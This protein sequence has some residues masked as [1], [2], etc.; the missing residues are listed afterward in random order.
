MKISIAALLIIL[1]ST[2]ACSPSYYKKLSKSK[3]QQTLVNIPDYSN[4]QYWAAHPHKID[5]SDSVPAPFRN[6][7]RDSAVDVFFIHPTTFTDPARIEEFNA[8]LTDDSLNIKTDY[9]SILYQASV[10]NGDCRVFAP[11]YRQAHIGMYRYKD[12]ARAWQAFDT[13]YADIRAAFIHYLEKYKG[14]PIIIASHSQGTQH[15]KRLLKEFFDGQTLGNRLVA[16]YLLG[17]PVDQQEFNDIPVC[18]DSTQTGCFVSWRTFRR[19]FEGPEYIARETPK[20]VV[21]PLTWKADTGYAASSL[22]KGAILYKFNKLIKSPN[23]AQVHDNILWVSRPKFPGASFY[24]TKN[25]HAG[26]YNLFY[27]NIRE[28]IRRRIGF[29]WKR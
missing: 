21:N 7:W 14:R 20:S 26:D 25:Y 19:N 27:Q 5:P 15:A 18:R 24:K 6:Q 2:N 22:H 16:A 9:T 13:A 29:F 4:L 10:F 3:W 1:L 23:D 12:T 17:I 11:R 28:D 8:K